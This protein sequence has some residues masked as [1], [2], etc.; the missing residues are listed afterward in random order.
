MNRAHVFP[1]TG[2]ARLV[3]TA[4]ALAALAAAAQAAAQ[5]VDYWAFGLRYAALDG[6][7]S[8]NAFGWLS[9]AMMAVAVVAFA[10]AALDDR[11][12]RASW[13]LAAIFLFL[14]VDNRL[15]LHELVANGKLL[16]TPLL[17]ALFLLVRHVSARAPGPAAWLLKA[18]LACLVVSF[19]AHIF[20]PT[21]L[22]WAGWGEQTWQD[23]TKVAIKESAEVAGWILISSGALAR[24]RTHRHRGP[25]NV[26]QA[27]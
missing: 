14:F 13:G 11:D 6:N 23:Q 12:K 26:P 3:A 21:I 7:S 20:G 19:T 17:A 4:T 10:A 9:A 16:F 2:T 8:A 22:S 24:L 18:G 5:L 15:D 27:A 1:A 25:G